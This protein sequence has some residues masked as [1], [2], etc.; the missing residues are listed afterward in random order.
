VPVNVYVTYR[1]ES[2][3]ADELVLAVDD[4]LMVSLLNR[5]RQSAN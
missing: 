1:L 5:V 4:L 2:L 3:S